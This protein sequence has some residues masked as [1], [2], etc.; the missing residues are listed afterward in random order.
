MIPEI[1]HFALIVALIVSLMG[2][3]IPH[4]AIARGDTR[5]MALAG[6]F[7]YSQF[8][9]ASVAFGALTYAY[10]ISDFSVL[11]VA[12]NSHTA[13]PLLYKVSGVWGNHE[14]SLMLWV[15][16]LSLFSACIALGGK[17]LPLRFRSRVLAVQ[18]A[19]LVGFLLFVLLTSNPF[20]RLD[21]APFE[22]NGLNPL[23]QDPGLAFH[24]PM[25]YIG[26]V[27]L[28][29]AFSFA[30][31]ALMEGEV[32]PLWA[33][34]VRPWTLAAWVFLTAGIALG[35]WWA[36]YELGWG[37][38][39]FWD[40]V[41][42]ASFMPWL[43]A[44]ALLHSSIVVEKRDALKS[45]TI[46]LAIVAFS[47]SLLGT[48]IVRSGVLTSVHAFAVDPERG[49]FI[50]AFL[51]VIIGGSLSLFA[52]RAPKLAPS[53][54]FSLAS[55]ESA[56]VLNNIL[57][58]TFAGVVLVGTLYP[59]LLEAVNGTQITVGPPFFEFAASVLMSPL[60]VALGFGP[61]LAWKRGNI[62][63]ASQILLPAVI[64]ALV[65]FWVTIWQDA[66]GTFMTGFGIALGLWLI[67]SVG[68]EINK[69]ANFWKHPAGFIG[70]AKKLPR[71][72]WGMS[73]AHAGLGIILL[74]IT[75]SEAWTSEALRLMKVG[76]S[77]NV[78][79]YDFTL[80]QV[81]PVA[82]PNYTAVRAR[83]L[84]EHNGRFIAKLAPE[85]RVYSDPPM[86]TT[87]AGIYPTFLGDVYAVI[88]EYAG[89]DAWS[90]RLY[91]K[92]LISGLWLGAGL[93]AIGGLISLSDRRQRIGA[94]AGKKRS[95]RVLKPKKAG[96]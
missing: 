41:E 31:A 37:G 13:K 45:W 90:V 11:N 95:K 61:L 78:G 28:S 54:I 2:A 7:A 86:N 46:L 33:R 29:V 56:L 36:Y 89:S 22:G 77:E 23:L 8:L 83:F 55:R 24:P 39:W 18:S 50:L 27:G 75:V 44:T 48:F 43:A 82:G 60:I 49:I 42:N 1:G 72:T 68:M 70:R 71:A 59:L 62:S 85:D 57:L 64:I 6:Q 65:V 73:L 63:R 88:G 26:Y 51:A 52:W 74:A 58:A 19:L 76:D 47:F 14:G 16:I 35:S 40:P 87:E 84:V 96:A 25:L 3:V 66:A 92:P 91:F 80:E 67:I 5:L 10:V 17:N 30:V 15:L 38:W 9:L 20:M 4:M 32:T 21:P 34:W 94:P 53:G 79:G 93:M 12:A 69:K 81:T